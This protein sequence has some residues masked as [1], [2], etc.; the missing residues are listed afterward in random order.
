M[1]DQ[2][3]RFDLTGKVALVTGAS[4]LLAARRLDRLEEVAQGIREGGG[5]A[6]PWPATPM[7]RTGVPEELAGPLLLLASDASGYMTGTALV[8]DGGT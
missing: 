7:R 4:L 3:F 2:P 1:T 6:S 8:V 5:S